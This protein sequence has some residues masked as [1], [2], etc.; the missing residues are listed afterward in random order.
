LEIAEGR[1][2]S[3]VDAVEIG[4]ADE[5]GGFTEAVSKTTQLA[6]ITKSYAL[7]EFNAPLTPIEEWLESL[8]SFD[9]VNMGAYYSIYSEEFKQL[10]LDNPM[11]ITNNGIQTILPGD[12][13]VEL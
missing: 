13:S 8:E 10:L 12:V 9:T 3:G 1:V 11:L 4:L 5:I 6:G 7:Y 2:W